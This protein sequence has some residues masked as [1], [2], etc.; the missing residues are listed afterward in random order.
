[1]GAPYPIPGGPAVSDDGD[2]RLVYVAEHGNTYHAD[3]GCRL[4]GRAASV[5]ALPEYRAL[6]RGRLPCLV[7]TP[8]MEGCEHG[9][10]DV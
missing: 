10:H 9:H 6:G 7:C 4:L 3:R 5:H 8:T 1:M 2:A